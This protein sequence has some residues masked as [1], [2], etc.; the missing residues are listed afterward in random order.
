LRNGHLLDCRV[1]RADVR[2]MFFQVYN[3]V[4][5]IAT[6]VHLRGL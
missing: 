2:S 5:E 6:S 4:Q 1:N 3:E